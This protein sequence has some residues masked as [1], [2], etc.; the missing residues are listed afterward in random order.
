MP[1][2]PAHFAT[3]MQLLVFDFAL[4][5]ES[6]QAGAALS[7]RVLLLYVWMLLCVRTRRAAGT[8]GGPRDGGRAGR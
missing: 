6:R 4:S 8:E 1:R 3:R 2:L 7:W 5:Q